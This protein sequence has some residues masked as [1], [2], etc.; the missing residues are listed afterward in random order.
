LS[1]NN[2]LETHLELLDETDEAADR[3][4]GRLNI[5][6]RK[7]DD[8]RRTAKKHRTCYSMLVLVLVLIITVGILRIII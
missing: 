1:I 7:L 6:Q 2:E 5:A 3:T 8:F 4:A